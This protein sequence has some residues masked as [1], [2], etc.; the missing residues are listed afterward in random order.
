MHFC[1]QCLMNDVV[2]GERGAVPCYC[3]QMNGRL[4]RWLV[5]ENQMLIVTGEGGLQSSSLLRPALGRE[6]EWAQPPVLFP[7]ALFLGVTCSIPDVTAD[8]T[9]LRC[10]AP[11]GVIVRCPEQYVVVRD[12]WESAGRPPAPPLSASAG[13][14]GSFWPS[15]SCGFGGGPTAREKKQSA[16]LFLDRE[17]SIQH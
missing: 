3:C 17:A 5:L 2:P 14:G 13:G 7:Q 12:S 9:P 16:V 6:G 1:P 4:L 15:G 10:L 8:P 11:S